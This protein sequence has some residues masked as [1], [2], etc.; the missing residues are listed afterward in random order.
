[1]TTDTPKTEA[2]EGVREPES[3][4]L[5]RKKPVVITA[6][7]YTQAVRDAHVLD[8]APLPEGVLIGAKDY[9]LG[10]REVHRADAYV[11][12]LEGRMKVTLNDWIITGVKGEHYAC[13]P[14]IFAAT[15][16]PAATPAAP[17]SAAPE[18]IELAA[19]WV[20]KRREDFEA[21][22]GS[23]DPETETLEFGRGV[24]A[25][26]K[27]EY[28]AELHEIAE[29]LR[30]L[31]SDPCTVPPGGWT[32]SRGTRH[33]GPCAASPPVTPSEGGKHARHGEQDS[34]S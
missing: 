15:Y 29:G 3:A 6:V 31:L 10:R 22:H 27:R 19:R 2:L 1:M 26:A 12:T 17:R 30:A 24:H 33:D 13:K 14:D 8:G 11:G 7:Q 9:H 4:N 28:V 20:D 18:G 32:C 16:E 23:V 34:A 21:E 25:E 5:Y